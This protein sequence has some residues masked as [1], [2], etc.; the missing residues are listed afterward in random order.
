MK[1]LLSSYNELYSNYSQNLNNSNF[2]EQSPQ[3]MENL[4]STIFNSQIVYPHTQTYNNHN[5]NKK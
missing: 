3:T 1:K 4:T 2:Q 5:D